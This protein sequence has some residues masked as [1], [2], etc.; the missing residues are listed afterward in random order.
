MMIP[1]G[2]SGGRQLT[3]TEEESRALSCSSS[4]GV[5]GP[6]E[7]GREREGEEAGSVIRAQDE[8]LTAAGCVS[9]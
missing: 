9:S 2:S 4:G 6:G 1:L 5:E 3:S 8:G 7:R